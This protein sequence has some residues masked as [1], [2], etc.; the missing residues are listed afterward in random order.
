MAF[1]RFSLQSLSRLCIYQLELLRQFKFTVLAFYDDGKP[2][3]DPFDDFLV[4]PHHGQLVNSP[5]TTLDTATTLLYEHI[6]AD[7]ATMILSPPEEDSIRPFSFPSSEV[8]GTG[9]MNA[10]WV[11]V[12]VI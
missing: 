12:E 7:I 9:V 2:D 1:R 6:P 5:Y 3:P 11:T 10:R 8:A 4:I